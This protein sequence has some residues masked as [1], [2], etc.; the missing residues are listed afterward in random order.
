MRTIGFRSQG[1]ISSTSIASAGRAATGRSIGL[2]NDIAQIPD[3]LDDFDWSLD[4]ECFLFDECG[5]LAS[6]IDAGKPVFQTKYADVGEESARADD[7]CA[8][9][10]A[11]G[12]ETLIKHL[13]LDAYRLA[14]R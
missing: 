7:V 3:L 14:C 6:F 11:R 12:F 2:K 9:A 8:D 13:E 1:T 10:N 4:E 5:G